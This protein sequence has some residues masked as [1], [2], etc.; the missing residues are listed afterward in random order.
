MSVSEQQNHTEIDEM[1][2][3]SEAVSEETLSEET[4]EKVSEGTSEE[5]KT[6]AEESKEENETDKKTYHTG[7]DYYHLCMH[8]FIMLRR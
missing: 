8:I 7:I 2:E 3:N 6:S 1:L 4:V 5:T